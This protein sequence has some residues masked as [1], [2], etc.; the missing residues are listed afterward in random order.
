MK[1]WSETLQER[2]RASTINDH[3][4]IK[5]LVATESLFPHCKAQIKVKLQNQIERAEILFKIVLI[6]KSL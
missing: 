6:L 2:F 3:D 5:Q 4:T 1:P